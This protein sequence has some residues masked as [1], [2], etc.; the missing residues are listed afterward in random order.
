M[1]MDIAGTRERN[2]IE[3]QIQLIKSRTVAKAVINKIWDAKK[4]GLNLLIQIHFTL[5]GVD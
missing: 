5:E 3:N 2:R 4:N 1:I